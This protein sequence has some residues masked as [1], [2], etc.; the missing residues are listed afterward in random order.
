[1]QVGIRDGEPRDVDAVLSLMRAL[2]EHEGLSELLAMNSE[3]LSRCCFGQPR[4]V[5][6]LVAEAEGRI[7]GYATCMLQFSPWIGGEYLFLDDLYVS[8]E[9][10]GLGVGSRLMRHIGALAV[11]RGVAVRW[12]VEVE[13]QSA[14]RF[15][16]ALGAELRAKLI[17]YWPT[18]SIRK[19]I[20]P[21]D[22]EVT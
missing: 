5:E 19:Q 3:L 4:R 7:V 10:R 6:L 12:H 14:S 2:A 22:S 13:N 15:Y 20:D 9:V 16:R 11:E 21:M 18:E 1:M 17:A 8:E